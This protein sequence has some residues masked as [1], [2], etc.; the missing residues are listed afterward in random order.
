[1]AR[2]EI[3]ACEEEGR[4]EGGFSSRGRDTRMGEGGEGAGGV[5]GG[6]RLIDT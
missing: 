2:E 1:M 3:V 4:R 6:V 5:G